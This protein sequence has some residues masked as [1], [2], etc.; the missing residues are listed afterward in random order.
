MD[1]YSINLSEV[2]TREI[3]DPTLFEIRE[4]VER[5]NF[6]NLFDEGE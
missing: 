5:D 2:Y 3:T 1:E 4:E 6:F